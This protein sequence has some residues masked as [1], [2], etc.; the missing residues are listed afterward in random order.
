MP[1][2]IYTNDLNYDLTQVSLS[3]LKNWPNSKLIEYHLE[4]N[5]LTPEDL[6]IIRSPK[7]LKLVKK[8]PYTTNKD[9]A[10]SLYLSF[11]K[12]LFVIPTAFTF[13]GFLFGYYFYFQANAIFAT[14]QYLAIFYILFSA[15]IYF[16]SIFSLQIVTEQIFIN[17]LSQSGRLLFPHELTQG[18]TAKFTLAWLIIQVLIQITVW[19]IS[20]T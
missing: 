7:Y 13:L 12:R 11:I 4:L 9:Y 15:A 1:K 10:R 8:H 17:K 16:S 20:T 5:K 18:L 3:D 2:V 19:L 6:E 14:V